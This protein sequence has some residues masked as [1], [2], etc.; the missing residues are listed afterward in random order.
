VH[1]DGSV[2]FDRTRIVS[3]AKLAA[4][5][6][7]YR[8]QNPKCSMSIVTDRTTNFEAIGRVIFAMQKA[9][10]LKVGFLTEPRND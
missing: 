1:A 5:L 7:Q 10:F 3:D 6:I 9:G 2:E 4:L 8:K